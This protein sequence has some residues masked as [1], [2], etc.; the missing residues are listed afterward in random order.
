M[1][2]S[3]ANFTSTLLLLYCSHDDGF[4]VLHILVFDN[5]NN[6]DTQFKSLSLRYYYFLWRNSPTRALA[7]SFSSFLQKTRAH[8]RTQTYTPSRALP[9]LWSAPR[10]DRKL[11]DTQQTQNIDIRDSKPRSQQSSGAADIDGVDRDRSLLIR[12]TA[13]FKISSTPYFVDQ[14]NHG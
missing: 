4:S 5:A 9:N 7:T 10:R 12:P 2:T 14:I 13:S 11:Q 1:A 8:A 3:T 6:V